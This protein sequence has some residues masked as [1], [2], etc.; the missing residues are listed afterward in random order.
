MRPLIAQ[1]GK[2]ASKTSREHEIW[3][4]PSGLVT[5][6]GGKLTTY[7]S[8]AEELVDLVAKQ[9]RDQFDIIAQV[10]A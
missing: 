2:S 10:R 6:A 5:I 9:L 3:T 4:T 8:M 7:R 1:I